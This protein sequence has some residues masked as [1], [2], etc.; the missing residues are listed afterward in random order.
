MA[1]GISAPTQGFPSRMMVRNDEEQEPQAFA[2]SHSTNSRDQYHG[3]GDKKW[4]QKR[5]QIFSKQGTKRVQAGT[6][7]YK[8]SSL[9]PGLSDSLSTLAEWGSLSDA[10]AQVHYLHQIVSPLNETLWGCC[11]ASVEETGDMGSLD[12]WCY[13]GRHDTKRA[14]FRA[15]STI[16]DDK[17]VC[18][19]VTGCNGRERQRSASVSSCELSATITFNDQDR[20]SES[21]IKYSSNSTKYGRRF[22]LIVNI[23]RTWVPFY[24]VF[25]ANNHTPSEAFNKTV[26]EAAQSLYPSIG[27][28]DMD[29]MYNA[30]SATARCDLT[31]ELKDIDEQEIWR[32]G[33]VFQSLCHD[34]RAE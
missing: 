1:S 26:E 30:C 13:E 34:R 9:N 21:N 31:E 11:G 8:L 20:T 25:C 12:G 28:K 10:F 16:H 22:T 15:D 14:R 32:A 33:K 4:A 3:W 23:L 27:Q 19:A 2:T 24:K 6:N 29:Y 5:R 18:C 7:R 17:L